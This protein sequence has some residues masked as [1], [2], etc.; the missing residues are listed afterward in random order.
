MGLVWAK[1]WKLFG[2][3]GTYKIYNNGSILVMIYSVCF[4]T[5][6]KIII[7]G[8]DNAGKTTILYQL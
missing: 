6:Y 3:E 1:L 7:T 4:Y 2:R 5:E 8:L